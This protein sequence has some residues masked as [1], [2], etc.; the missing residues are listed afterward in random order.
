MNTLFL[1]V[2][3]TQTPVPTGP[4]QCSMAQV[5]PS[6][7][8]IL[9]ADFHRSIFLS[10]D[11]GDSDVIIV[12]AGGLENPLA[13]ELAQF[14]SDL[15]AEGW[16][17]TPWIMSG[18]SAADL[19][20]F[21][22]MHSDISGAVL[23]GNLP[24]AWYEMDEFTGQHEEF[25]MDLYLMDL[26]GIW[27]DS[28]ADGLLDGHSG[29]KAPEIWVGRIDAHAMEFGN[30]ISLLKDY[31]TANHL[32]RTGSLSVPAR[33]L[34]FNDNDW[35][36][37]GSSGLEYIYS[38]VEVI[39]NTSQTTADNY[40]AELAEGYEFV[41]LMSH[42][43]PWGHTFRIPSGYGGT[44]LA[45]E[46]SCVNPQTVFV[47]LFACSNCRWTEPDCLGNWYLFG[48]DYGLLAIGS[49]KTG[50]MLDFSEFYEPIGSG[51]IP[52]VAFRAW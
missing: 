9:P 7:L 50:A 51:N 33:A 18:G 31:F 20:A 38:T 36:Y 39:N 27:T 6:P 28:D 49:T 48:T 40:K 2:L 22:Q 14:E 47:Q 11:R 30:E 15:S 16:N 19:R 3:L 24:R 8:S 52:G 23:V 26:D 29:D 42:S 34:A 1:L 13:S 12:I 4:V 41:H 43:S 44:V 45:P 21:L 17:V 10:P 37:Y 35:S 5:E 46:I 32:Y 25:P